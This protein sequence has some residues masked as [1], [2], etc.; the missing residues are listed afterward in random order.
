LQRATI[1]IAGFTGNS[2]Q[3]GTWRADLIRGGARQVVLLTPST[4]DELPAVVTPVL[5]QGIPHQAGC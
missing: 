2:S 5:S 3:E 1:A 4:N